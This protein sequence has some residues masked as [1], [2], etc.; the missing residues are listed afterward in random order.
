MPLGEAGSKQPRSCGTRARA[1]AP[2][3]TAS[4]RHSL[5]GEAAFPGLHE[6]PAAG[7]SPWFP[8]PQRERN[9][10]D[11]LRPP[12]GTSPLKGEIT[13]NPKGSARRR[14]PPPSR[15]VPRG[16]SQPPAAQRNQNLNDF[17]KSLR[18]AHP[19]PRC[20]VAGSGGHRAASARPGEAGP[21]R[22]DLF[23]FIPAGQ[24]EPGGAAAPL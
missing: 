19:R 16:C 1:P 15:P 10:S 14:S 4:S 18:G 6:G 9:G 3:G 11:L 17:R 23:V 13:P 22:F 7:C 12:R 24:A 21:R 8:H 5:P 2:G 20:P